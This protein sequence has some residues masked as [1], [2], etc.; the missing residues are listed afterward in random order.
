MKRNIALSVLLFVF[1]LSTN[2][3]GQSAKEAVM[4]LKKLQVRYQTGVSYKDYPTALADAKFPVQLY[5]ESPEAESTPELSEALKN[6]I[7]YLDKANEMVSLKMT[8][9]EIDGWL[10]LATKEINKASDLLASAE[11]SSKGKK[12]GSNAQKQIDTLKKEIEKLKKEN[13]NLKKENE[14]LKAKSN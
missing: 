4:A 2:A 11:K 9:I 1:A 10:E 3:F 12:A 13:I 7:S 6:A 8:Q 5:L 14:A